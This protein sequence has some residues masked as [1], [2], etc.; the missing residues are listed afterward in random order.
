[1][2][3][4]S[5]DQISQVFGNDFF[6]KGEWFYKENI[7]NG[8]QGHNGIDYGC[9][10]GTPVRA[11]YDMEITFAS[12]GDSYGKLV[13][14]K[15]EPFY[16]NN[17]EY[18]LESVFAHLG[19]F[20]CKA[21]DMVKK[22]DIIALSGNS[23]PYT[24]GPHLH[25]GVRL[26]KNGV[27]EDY[28]NGYFGYFDQMFLADW[29]QNIRRYENQLVKAAGPRHYIAKDGLLYWVE[30]EVALDSTGRLFEEAITIDPNLVIVSD[31][32]YYKVDYEEHKTKE[33]K[34][35][36]SLLKDNPDRA[37]TLFNKYF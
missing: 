33:T 32:Q 18:R 11:P 25:W 8:L 35:L 22:D 2:V 12:G 10:I 26:H 27:V 19:T 9:P 20:K 24:T 5:D 30:D 6:Y 16:Y 34:Q 13:R 29:K 1:M 21:G 3:H 23:G 28:N 17:A 15:S 14:G 36:L 31:V 4:P 37:K 7:N